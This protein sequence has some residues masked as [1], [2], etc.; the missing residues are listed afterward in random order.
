MVPGRTVDGWPW[1]LQYSDSIVSAPANIDV[2]V[3][4]SARRV[5]SRAGL[6]QAIVLGFEFLLTCRDELGLSSVLRGD[7][8]GGTG[9]HTALLATSA[10]VGHGKGKHRRGWHCVASQQTNQ[11][12]VKHRHVGRKELVFHDTVV[13]R[14]RSLRNNLNVLCRQVIDCFVRLASSSLQ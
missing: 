7:G 14:V 12:G 2:G 4:R 13:A 10:T 9:N 3:D 5:T 11:R 1:R 8:G 6:L